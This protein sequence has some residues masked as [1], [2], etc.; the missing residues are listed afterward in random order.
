MARAC[1]H[2]R[3]EVG[4]GS[5]SRRKL[6]AE[7]SAQPSDDGSNALE[8]A[9]KDEDEARAEYL[10]AVQTLTEIVV[11]GEIPKNTSDY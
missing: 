5:A 4:A 9:R 8:Q 7:Y 2:N 6:Q 10:I 11:K 3:G 1:P